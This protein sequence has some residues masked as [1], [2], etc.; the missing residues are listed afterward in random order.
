MSSVSSK[1]YIPQITG[2]S[3]SN[4]KGIKHLEIKDLAK[5][6]LFIGKNNSGKSTI[7]EALYYTGKEFLSPNLPQCVTRRANRGQWSARE[8]FYNYDFSLAIDTH[9][10]FEGEDKFG[11]NLR[12]LEEQQTARIEESLSRETSSNT[13]SAIARKYNVSNFGCVWDRGSGTPIDTMHE[14]ENRAYFDRSVFIDPTL[15]SDVIQ[16]ENSYLNKLELSETD[17]SD[18]A[19]KAADIYDIKT[20]WGFL[21]HQDFHPSNPSRFSIVEGERRIF[22]DDFGD[23]L[24]YGLAILAAAKTRKNTALF[25]EEIECHQHL[26]AIKKLIPHLLNIAIENNLQLFI[27]TQNNNIWR[28]FEIEVSENLKRSDLLKTYLVKRSPDTHEI[29]CK[30][31]TKDE[32]DEFWTEVDTEL[33]GTPQLHSIQNSEKEG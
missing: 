11:M 3:V 25:I 8:L 5:V 20:K 19:K 31:L 22:L 17:S 28:L 30:P 10:I 1:S 26:A 6:N 14:Q 18:L 9:V 32:A 4:F 12:F 33:S 21:P 2:L 29:I 27:T 7:M 13:S 24:H 15:K 23:G 16:I